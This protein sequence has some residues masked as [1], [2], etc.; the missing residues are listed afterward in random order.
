MIGDAQVVQ[1]GE[2]S[3]GDGKCFLTKIR[4]IKFLHQ[5][6]GFDVLAF[7]SGLYDCHRS[8]QAFKAGQNGLVASRLGVFGIWTGSRQTQPLWDYLQQQASGTR[9]LELAG[10]DCQYTAGASSQHLI[11]DLKELVADSKFEAEAESLSSFYEDI[12]LLAGGKVPDGDNQRFKDLADEIQVHLNGAAA[13]GVA[14]ERRQFWQQQLKSMVAHAAYKWHHGDPGDAQWAGI[15]GRDAQMADNLN[16]LATTRY[17][18]RKIIVWAA[19]FHIVRN[20]QQIKAPDGKVDYSQITQMGHEAHK[21]LASKLYTIGFTAYDGKAGTYFRPSWNIDKAVGGTL[22][23]VCFQAQ[24]ENALVPLTDNNKNAA[25]EWLGKELYSRPLGYSWMRSVWP[26][27][28]DAM[29]FNRTMTP[30]TR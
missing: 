12:K 29:I 28:F 3:H 26:N 22:E 1:L 25:A 10:F 15:E 18:D 6:M 7:E 2:Q 13:N 9:P 24:L 4:L 19:S 11:D 27:K 5:E 20:I 8:W 30:S 14:A 16:W 21:R 23:D 17:P